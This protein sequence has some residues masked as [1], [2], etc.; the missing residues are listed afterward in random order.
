[1][2]SLFKTVIKGIR[3]KFQ[4]SFINVF[5]VTYIFKTKKKLPVSEKFLLIILFIQY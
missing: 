5:K 2:K 1:M 4:L 3:F